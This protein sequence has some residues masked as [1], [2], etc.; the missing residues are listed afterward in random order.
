MSK[1]GDVDLMVIGNVGLAD[2]APALRKAEARLGRDVNV[3]TYSTREFRTK[4]AARDP[5]LS[6]VLRGLKQF[7]KGSHHDLGKIIGTHREP[8]SRQT[9]IVLGSA[10]RLSPGS[11]FFHCERC[12]RGFFPSLRCQRAVPWRTGRSL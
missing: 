6:T 9:C 2:L 8:P 5:F 10:V 3:T 1:R 11:L 12:G 7:V 4:M